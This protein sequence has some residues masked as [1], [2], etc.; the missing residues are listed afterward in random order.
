MSSVLNVCIAGATGWT[1]S[2]LA[3]A[4]ADADDLVLRCAVSR[5]RAGDELYGA[6]VH[7][8]V[9]EAL[10]AAGDVDVLIDYT[11]HD[12]VRGHTLAAIERGV[13]VVVGTSGLTAADFE[14][15]QAVAEARG[16]GVV[17][18]GNFSITSAWSGW[19]WRR[20]EL[21]VWRAAGESCSS[22]PHGAYR[23]LHCKG[24]QAALARV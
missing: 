1:G 22:A 2:A 7:A 23:A 13:G 15:I 8:T 10:Y 18:A 4:V 14:E 19:T 11:S 17:A 6:P 20:P 16:V 5:S 21:T 3:A 9:V 12:V 24:F